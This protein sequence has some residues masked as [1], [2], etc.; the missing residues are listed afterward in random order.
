MSYGRA[1]EGKVAT[2]LVCVSVYLCVSVYRIC[3]C[4]CMCVLTVCRRTIGCASRRSARTVPAS[5][6]HFHL[7]VVSVALVTANCVLI[8]FFAHVCFLLRVR[9]PKCLARIPLAEVAGGQFFSQVRMLSVCRLVGRPYFLHVITS[10]SQL[11]TSS[12]A[13]I[14]LNLIKLTYS[15][16]PPHS[17]SRASVSTHSLSTTQRRPLRH[18]QSDRL[19]TPG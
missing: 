18:L 11:N 2:G 6:M 3:M 7:L 5:G 13:C 8:V 1:T 19:S 9:R 4:V 15:P 14:S 10:F 17:I 12:C 16:R